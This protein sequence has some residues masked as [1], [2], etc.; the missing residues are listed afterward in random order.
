MAATAPA[1]SAATTMGTRRPS[2]EAFRR[3]SSIISTIKEPK[4]FLQ[5]LR[6]DTLP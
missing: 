2:R 5:V 1:A 4:T 6:K 3:Q